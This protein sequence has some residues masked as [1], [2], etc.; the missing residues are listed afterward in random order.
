MIFPFLFCRP[1]P[2]CSVVVI[3]SQLDK[4]EGR[5]LFLSCN[6][7]SVDEKTLYSEATGKKLPLA[8]LSLVSAVWVFFCLGRGGVGLV[9]FGFLTHACPEILNSL[10]CREQAVLIHCFPVSLKII[11]M[12]LLTHFQDFIPK[13]Y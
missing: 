5:K 3:N 4:L 9:W 7:R 1:V 10:S 8:I 6:V 12:C 13:V 2:L 11:V